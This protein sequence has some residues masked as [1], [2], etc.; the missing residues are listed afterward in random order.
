M[1][2]PSPGV[3]VNVDVDDLPRAEAFYATAFNLSP[4]RRFGEHGVELLGLPAPL[5][6]LRKPSG[7]LA[8]PGEPRRRRNYSRH[9]TPV[10]LDFVVPDIHAALHRA[11]NAGATLEQPVSAQPY[12]QIALLAD[13]FGNGFCLVEFGDRGYDAIATGNGAAT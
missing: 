5:Y 13:P 10:H 12:G 8:I 1:T 9:W 6:L 11:L 2:G 3:L 4:A 7:T